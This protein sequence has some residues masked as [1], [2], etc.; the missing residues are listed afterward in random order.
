MTSAARCS[1]RGFI[2]LAYEFLSYWPFIVFLAADPVTSAA[3]FSGRGY[4]ELASS[5]LPTRRTQTIQLT[6]QTD[7]NNGVMFW[8]GQLPENTIPGMDYIALGMRDGRA[9]FRWI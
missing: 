2:E 5:L 7:Q 9:V 6:V 3:S 4:I 1:E 8:Y